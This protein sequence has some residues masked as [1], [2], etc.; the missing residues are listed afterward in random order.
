MSLQSM[1][2]DMNV[3]RT[4][5]LDM[6]SQKIESELKILFPKWYATCFQIQKLKYSLSLDMS[7]QPPSRDTDDFDL[8]RWLT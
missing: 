7:H 6:I 3:L 5:Y 1:R 4:S 8:D 2:F